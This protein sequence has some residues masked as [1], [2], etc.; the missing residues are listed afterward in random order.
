MQNLKLLIE[1]RLERL[2]LQNPLR[3]DFQKHYEEI[4]AAYNS[5]KDRVT[6]ERTFEML[7]NFHETMSVEESRAVRE[8]LDEESLAVFDLLKKSDLSAA[9]IK[10]IKAIAVELPAKLKAEKLR[11]D[12]WREKEATRDA[13]KSCI[14][15]F[16]WGDA[17]G[18]PEAYSQAEIQDKA[19]AVFVHVSCAYSTVPSP[20]YLRL[21]S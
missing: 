11:V 8:G 6:I 19:E 4:V 10:R 12:H 15:D 7:M 21:A 5:E 20:Y 13:V 1:K 3:T 18:L 16:L 2:L 9:E 17:T 14:H